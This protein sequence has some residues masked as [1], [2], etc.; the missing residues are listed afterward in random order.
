M[1]QQPQSANVRPRFTTMYRVS[2][3]AQGRSG[4]GLEAQERMVRDYVASVGG[5]IVGAFT[6][7]ESGTKAANRPEL[8]RALLH[9]R[10]TKS[11]LLTA[12]LDRLAREVSFVS[13]LLDSGV[14]FRAADMPAANRFM[15]QVVACVAEYEARLIADRTRAGLAARRA[16]GLPLGGDRRHLKRGNA[17]AVERNRAAAVAS[18]ER[19]RPVLDSLRRDGVDTLRELARALEDRGYRTER[20]GA[21]TIGVLARVVRRLGSTERSQPTGKA[22]RS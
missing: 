3:K 13:K 6:E 14:E 12:R 18:A 9:A 11:I 2:T 15:I 10:R 1:P 22:A 21:W 17:V 16:R 19:L 8:A 7:V 5:E 4:L 20:G